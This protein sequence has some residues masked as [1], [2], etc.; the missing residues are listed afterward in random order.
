MVQES[1]PGGHTLPLS[2]IQDNS[3]GGDT[4]GTAN[5][6]KYPYN[7]SRESGNRER[8]GKERNPFPNHL[9]YFP[10]LLLSFLVFCFKFFYVL[11]HDGKES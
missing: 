1:A 9:F 8:R 7:A 6:E 4:E 2:R 5:N 10:I 3:A 11:D